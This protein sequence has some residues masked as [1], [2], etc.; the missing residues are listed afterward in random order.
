MRSTR[1]GAAMTTRASIESTLPRYGMTGSRRVVCCA[2]V[3][4]SPSVDL[5][6][7][8]L[9][10]VDDKSTLNG[11]RSDTLCTWT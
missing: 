11:S 1:L 5:T 3:V 10:A 2:L 9:P 6:S 4:L 8:F 7:N